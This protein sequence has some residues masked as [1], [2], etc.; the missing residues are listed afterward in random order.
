MKNLNEGKTFWD[1]YSQK[2]EREKKQNEKYEQGYRDE[3]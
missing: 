1:I 3:L 2:L